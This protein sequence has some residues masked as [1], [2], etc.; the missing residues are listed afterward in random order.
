MT[1]HPTLWEHLRL[2]AEA[3]L[4]HSAARRKLHQQVT[5]T[6]RQARREQREFRRQTTTIREVAGARLAEFAT[7]ALRTGHPLD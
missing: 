1:G 5:R 7:Q 4:R 3:R 2:R 6:R